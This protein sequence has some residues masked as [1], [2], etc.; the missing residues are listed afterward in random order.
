M[1]RR[2]GSANLIRTGDGE[3][4]S[5]TRMGAS[6]MRAGVA[7][8]MSGVML[9]A[10]V[11]AQ[12]VFALNF[13]PIEKPKEGL[14]IE[15]T[16]KKAKE[17]SE[18]GNGTINV[19]PIETPSGAS[20]GGSNTDS[21]GSTGTSDGVTNG[22]TAGTSDGVTNGGTAGT[23]DGA[24]NGG[25][26]GT[27]DGAANGGS[28]G[29]SDGAANGGSAGTSDGSTAHSSAKKKK[30]NFVNEP[31]MQGIYADSIDLSGM[32]ADQADQAIAAYIES[33]G[34]TQITMTSDIG[35][36]VTT[37]WELG[38]SGT[39]EDI[40]YEAARYGRCGNIVSRYKA[41][42]DLAH[43]G[44]VFDVTWSFD[45]NSISDTIANA[46]A[47][48]NVP[49]VNAGLVRTADGFSVTPGSNGSEV[50]V[51]ESANTL[52]AAITDPN[53]AGEALT[54]P[55]A[56]DVVEPV[57]KEED[58]SK[59]TDVLGAFTTRYTSSGAARCANIANGCKL[60]SGST[61]YPGEEFSVL[62]H[63][64]PFSEENGYELAGSYINGEVV[65]SLGGGI[66]QVSTT[67]YN[68][69]LRAEMEVTERHNHSMIV[70]YV[71]PSDDAAI[72]ESSGKDFKFRNNLEYPVY[73]DGYT[74]DKTITFTLFGCET[75]DPGR[76]VDFES[77]VLS[78]TDPGTQILLDGQMAVGTYTRAG[79]HKGYTAE[80]WKIVNE[81]GNETRT[82]VNSS[83]YKA[84]PA[85]VRLGVLNADA[86][87]YSMLAAAASTGDSA[88]AIAAAQSVAAGIV[89]PVPTVAA[90]AAGGDSAAQG[91]AAQATSGAGDSQSNTASSGE[92]QSSD[93]DQGSPE[94]SVG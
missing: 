82:Q 33:V 81:N 75:R 25:S 49:A 88:T 50:N 8:V 48:I 53:W 57:G 62:E 36:I 39:G 10:A 17:K 42:A 58:L 9:S 2:N 44:K 11:P 93:A 23:S 94:E 35:N 74:A 60:V 31:I 56:V 54:L 83:S 91:G 13:E 79:V 4:K 90:E 64:T 77:V 26:T 76:S 14:Q 38:F 20:D 47:T 32:T 61:V 30:G 22:G 5:L 51:D 68:A 7:L 41:E 52:Y 19:E 85:T 45:R 34:N 72:A 28:A 3:G 1:K 12:R 73:I 80:L 46:A 6:F 59:V 70:N 78:E 21:S 43:G 18:T 24:A 66:C 27:S 40:G 71:D 37:G 63:L 16:G 86:G 87:A 29:T 92:A 69:V 15:D 89:L 84:V 55:L 65:D 67:L